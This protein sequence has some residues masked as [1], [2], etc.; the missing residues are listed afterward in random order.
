[1]VSAVNVLVLG[2][3]AREHALCAALAASPETERLLCVPGNPGISRVATCRAELSATDGAALVSLCR[4]EKIAL[5]VVGPEAPLV[6]GVADSLRSAGIAVFGSS[7]AAAQVEGSKAFAKQLMRDA[8]IPTADYAVFDTPEAARAHAKHRG[9]CVVKADGLAAGKGVVVAKSGDEAA[10]AVDSLASSL[11]REAV[12]RWV[13]EDV[14]EGEEGSAIAICDGER[15]AMLPPAQDHNRLRDGDEGPNTGGMGAYA[16][17]PV[18]PDTLLMDVGQRVI[19]P[20]LRTLAARGTPFV[21]ALYAGLMVKPS[22]GAALPEYSVL[23]FNA[24]LGDPECQVMLMRV[25][26]DLLPWLDGAARGKLP[27][28]TM[29]LKP[30][31]ALGVVLASAGYPEKPRSGDVITGIDRAEAL[32]ARV[33]HAGT[34]MR[35]AELVTAGGRVL[36]VC[37]EGPDLTSAR[38]LA[39]RAAEQIRFD[40]M[41]LRHDV[42]ARGLRG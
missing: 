39:Y 6:A 24:R 20:A 26:G 11:G 42:G 1:M 40:G 36:T 19:A 27:G 32:G 10:S 9:A 3:G 8:N 33:Y 22:K 29:S 41:Q 4:E 16:P 23:E 14:L 34:R 2:S 35:G 25:A 28:A 38:A 21:G 7:Q 15:Y 31:A 18:L 37:G 12:S 17:A 5:C 30:G 13:I